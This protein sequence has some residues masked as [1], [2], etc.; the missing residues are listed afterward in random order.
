[1]EKSINLQFEQDFTDPEFHSES[2]NTKGIKNSL[3]AMLILYPGLLGYSKP[4]AAAQVDYWLDYANDNLFI[5]DFKKLSYFFDQLDNH[6]A[7]RS[8]FVGYV[9]S[10]A[11]FAVFGALKANA[12]FNKQLKNGKIDNTH[13]IRW[14]DHMNSLDAVKMALNAVESAKDAV[15]DRSDKGSM[16]IPLDG[17]E[18]GKVVTRFPPEPSFNVLCR[19]LPS[20]WTRESG[21]IKQLFCQKLQW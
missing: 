15:K 21:V 18:M 13:L 10:A 4:V 9:L 14:Y 19:W 20:Y 7:L 12:I 3:K 11:D 1:M 17:A 6:L 16:A 5:S 8:F 2:V